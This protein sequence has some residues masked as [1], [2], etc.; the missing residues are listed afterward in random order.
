M[1]N[2]SL[3]WIEKELLLKLWNDS[4]TLNAVLGIANV[5]RWKI[6]YPNLSR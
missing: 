4:A 2:L 3:M 6:I 1:N 5:K